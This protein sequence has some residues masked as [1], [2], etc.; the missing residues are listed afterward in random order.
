MSNIFNKIISSVDNL[1]ENDLDLWIVPELLEFYKEKISYL[2]YKSYGSSSNPVS[3]AAFKEQAKN[4]LRSACFSFLFKLEHWKTKRDLNPYLSATLNRLGNKLFY[5]A[6]SVKKINIPICP[7]CKY[8]GNKEYLFN[9]NDLLRCSVCTNE[10]DR[11]IKDFKYQGF[12]DFKTTILFESR[13]KIHKSFSL[14]SLNGF[15]CPECD[16]FIPKSLESQFGISCPY[17]ECS[18]SG[19]TEGLQKKIHPVGFGQR[20]DLSLQTPTGLKNNSSGSAINSNDIQDYFSDDTTINPDVMMEIKENYENELSVLKQVLDD[21]ISQVKRTNAVGTM[22]QKL[23]M[24]EAYK[25][26]LD[27]CPEDMV[28]YLVH[29]RQ[30]TECPVQSRIFQEYVRII[31]ESLP[32]DI[33]INKDEK[34]TICSLTDPNLQLFLGKSEFN[35]LVGPDGVIPNL[36]KETYVGSVSFKNYGS[37]FIGQVIDVVRKNTGESLKNNIKNYTFVQIQMEDILPGTEVTVTHFRINSHYEVGATV[38]IQRVRK[39]IVDS[40]YFRLNGEHRISG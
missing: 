12:K 1:T 16:G 15:R 9:E 19:K 21:Q 11:L 4:S 29:R 25:N 22:F 8:L 5:D 23:S 24:Y 34:Y 13:I 37:C 14:H 20:N 40:V 27:Q 10:A 2:T 36:T 7:G 38:N 35:A 39:R 33:Q 6:E 18:F 32:Y 31:E 26:M 3:S 30:N 28:S 17:S